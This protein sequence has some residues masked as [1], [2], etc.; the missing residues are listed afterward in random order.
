MPASLS[1]YS[2]TLV[3]GDS[4]ASNSP[5]LQ[6]VNWKRSLRDVQVQDP[7]TERISLSPGEELLVFD[8]VRNTNI[9]ATTELDLTLSTL[10]SD[11]YRFAWN[12][13]GTAPGFRFEKAADATGV[14]L[15]LTANA[16]GSMTVLAASAIF[17]SAFVGDELFIPGM[18][19]GDSSTPFSSL[20][21]GRWVV[22]GVGGSLD[23]LT[24]ARPSGESFQ[25][26]SEV[27]TPTD[28]YQFLLYTQGGVQVGDGLDVSVGFNA[29]ALKT[30][31][32]VGVTSRWVEVKSTEPLAEETGITPDFEGFSIFSAAK[33]Y[34]RIEADQDAVL[35][36]N[37]DTSSSVRVSPW[38]A[39]DPDQVG[40]FTKTGP[41]WS[42]S[43]LNRSSQVL[44][45][46]V[47]SVE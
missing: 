27:V 7:R 1:L 37:G 36:L 16:N 15:T 47:I 12:G 45:L 31:E 3:S 26:V 5:A 23:T 44:N 13:S 30:Y 4:L 8:G 41:T 6:F 46:T 19:T 43:V 2:L 14:Q 29:S 18:M 38:A 39:G 40:E 25:G 33:R 9:N 17:A 11:V 35:R 24:I 22:L 28:K 10:A 42:L 20:N 34:L 32:I 21:Q